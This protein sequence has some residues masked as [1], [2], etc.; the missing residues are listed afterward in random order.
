MHFCAFFHLC[1]N[2]DAWKHPAQNITLAVAYVEAFCVRLSQFSHLAR[3][4]V[5]RVAT[6]GQYLACCVKYQPSCSAE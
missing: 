3:I 6:P 2:V 1:N 4:V 5:M